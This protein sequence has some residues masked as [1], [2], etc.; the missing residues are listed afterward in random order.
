MKEL[1]SSFLNNLSQVSSELSCCKNKKFHVDNVSFCGI[2][3]VLHN[4]DRS[5]TIDKEKINTLMEL[6]KN[7]N[8]YES[9]E[10][11][12]IDKY[13]RTKN[14]NILKNI[15]A[16]KLNVCNACTLCN[17][18]KKNNQ[19]YKNKNMSEN[20]NNVIDLDDEILIAN[21]PF[22]S[23][24]DVENLTY[25]NSENTLNNKEYSY[26]KSSIDVDLDQQIKNQKKN[27]G[28]KNSSHLYN[29]IVKDGEYDNDDSQ[30]LDEEPCQ[31]KFS[32]LN[33]I[34]NNIHNDNEDS[35][36]NDVIIKNTLNQNYEKNIEQT[37]QHNIIVD[38]MMNAVH[39]HNDM[40]ENIKTK[41]KKKNPA[42]SNFYA[43]SELP[44][45]NIDEGSCRGC[46][47][48]DT[49]SEFFSVA[50]GMKPNN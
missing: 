12:D 18:N 15:G 19:N 44:S 5:S 16:N 2:E 30:N 23:L 48:S 3:D 34:K 1:V 28:S 38:N 50:S 6:Y 21:F 39:S 10:E 29:E 43:K 26:I 4:R 13:E 33:N 7:E 27:N 49:S 45:S 41:K 42:Y 36:N 31:F 22:N 47:A 32:I 35:T 14:N 9:Y 20:I 24:R 8:M 17:N 37:E 25:T 46:K 40:D 11:Y